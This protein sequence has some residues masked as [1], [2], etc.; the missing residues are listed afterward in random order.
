IPMELGATPSPLDRLSFANW[1]R[2]ERFDAPFLTW[3]LNYACRDDYGAMASATSAWAGIHYFASREYDDLGPFTWPEGNGWII[4]RL[5]ATLQPYVQTAT[6]VHHIAPAGQGLQVWTDQ[7]A[8][9]AEIVIFAAPTF[10]A[11][12]IVEGMPPLRDFVYSPWLTAN[13]TL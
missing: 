1:C 8:Y 6:M 9:L 5:L 13:L 11:S 4:R 7:S 2:Q 12:Y 10:L 3:Y